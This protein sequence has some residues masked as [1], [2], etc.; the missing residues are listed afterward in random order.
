[1]MKA[2]T[3]CQA[4]VAEVLVIIQRVGDVP[5]FGAGFL[6]FTRR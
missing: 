2:Q 4:V 3:K 6:T 5:E 1:L